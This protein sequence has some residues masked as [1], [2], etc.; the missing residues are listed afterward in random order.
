MKIAADQTENE[1][2]IW[3][4]ALEVDDLE[5]KILGPW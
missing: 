3:G 4:D 2:M 1:L 5:E